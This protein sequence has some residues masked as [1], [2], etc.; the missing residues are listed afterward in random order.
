MSGTA[1]LGGPRTGGGV[2]HWTGA[3]FSGRN[4]PRRASSF[5]AS[6]GTI[7]S[8]RVE[9]SHV[10]AAT[11]AGAVRAPGVASP[12][13]GPLVFAPFARP[14]V[15]GGRRLSEHLGKRLPGPGPYGESWEISAHPLHHSRVAAGPLA[16]LTLAEVAARW[17]RAL[18]GDAAPARFPWLVKFLDCHQRLSVQVHPSDAQVGR[19]SAEPSGKTEC[20]VVLHAEP[21]AVVYAGLRPGVGRADLERHAAAGTVE[22]C[23]HAFAPRAGDCVHLPAGTVHATGGGLVLAEVQQ[24]SDATLRLFDW[25]RVGPDGKPRQLHVAAALDAIDWSDPGP[26]GPVVPA[27]LPD[28]A[29]GVAAERLV[30]CPH[31]VLER[32]RVGAAF[33]PPEGRLSAWAVLDGAA[34]LVTPGRRG[35]AAAARRDRRAAGGAPRPGVAAGRPRPPGHATRRPP[36]RG[37]LLTPSSPILLAARRRDRLKQDRGFSASAPGATYEWPDV[38]RRG[39]GDAGV[40]TGGVRRG[41]GGRVRVRV[42]QRLPRHGQRRRGGHL[43]ALDLAGQAGGRGLQRLLQFPRRA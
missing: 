9:M 4:R 10:V 21:G 19:W 5:G 22:A 40:A 38:F 2:L 37:R 43:H 3:I 41:A 20:C 17:P 29:A 36:A 16:G 32:F 15:W 8:G 33:A 28:P 14:M 1:F 42:H 26:V 39:H 31:F 35:V 6:V 23:L 11:V 34:E 13:D 12:P 25:N 24:T 30:A 7:G 27:R 18:Y